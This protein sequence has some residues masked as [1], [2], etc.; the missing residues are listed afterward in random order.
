[1]DKEALP[2]EGSFNKEKEALATM[3][4]RCECH[5]MCQGTGCEPRRTLEKLIEEAEKIDF[6]FSCW[7]GM[8]KLVEAYEKDV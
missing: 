4:K 5:E 2:L 7:D 3:C 6:Y 8:M 1:M